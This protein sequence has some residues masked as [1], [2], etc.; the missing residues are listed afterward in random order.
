MLEI[1][2]FFQALL[3]LG[4]D[5]KSISFTQMIARAISIY[6]IG[7]LMLRVGEHRFLGKNTAFDIVLGFIF[8]SL[9]SRAINGSAPF[10]ET[11]IA[12]LT[13]LTL[14]WV[15]LIVAFH[16]DRLDLLINGKVRGLIRDG[17]I[18]RKQMRKARLND[19]ILRENL[20]L[21]GGVS[22]PSQV[23]RADFEPSGN[24]SVIPNQPDREPRVVNVDVREGV[25]T[26]RIEIA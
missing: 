4:A 1:Q 12:G 13:L 5:P 23:H 8:G 24:V 19:R 25:Q 20:R 21:N 10:S 18:N 2:E 7:W 26:V 17:E 11:I 3:G 9:L 16:S 14:H 6:L 22:D 15:F